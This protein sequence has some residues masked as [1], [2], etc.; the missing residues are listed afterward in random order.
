MP[1]KKTKDLFEE[2]IQDKR[3]VYSSFNVYFEDESRFG[4]FTRNG[5][6]LTAKGIKP[7]C[8]YHHKFENLYLFGAF[9]PVNG[10]SLLLEMPYCNTDTFQVFLNHLSELDNQEF[11]IVVL[12]NGA[13]HKAKRLTIPKNIGFIFL[14]PYSP[15]LNPA[16]QIWRV[17]K[18]SVCNKVFKS[19]D[20]LSDHL[21]DTIQK[22]ITNASVKSITGYQLF[23]S[24]YQTIFDL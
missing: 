16:E 20:E 14:P 1:L 6:A 11:K 21:C 10:S 18:K 19:L 24:A 15:E 2:L 3:S 7:V 22:T 9:S 17:L 5:R 12:D 8:P 23:L 13:F 4:L